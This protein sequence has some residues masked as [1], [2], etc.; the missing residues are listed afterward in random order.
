[1]AKPALDGIDLTALTRTL[2]PDAGPPYPLGEG[3][4]SRAFG[5]DAGTERY[6]LRIGT[7][8]RGFA[9]DA[10]AARAFPG[11]PVPEVV[12]IG[13]VGPYVY[14]LSRRLPG[15][16]VHAVPTDELGP[17]LPAVGETL[18]ALWATDV[19]GTTGYGL[20][21]GS[22]AG[23]APTW[24][25]Y[26]LDQGPVRDADRRG[27]PARLVDG[28]CRIVADRVDDCPEDR[29]LLHGDFG[30]DNAL[31]DGR[32]IT[33]VLNWELAA[34]GDPL[35]DVAEMFQWDGVDPCMTAQAAWFRRTLPAHDLDS[36]RLACYRARLCL[37]ELAWGDA[38]THEW[39]L[40]VA[41]RLLADA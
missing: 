14:C 33:G 15:R 23:A 17:V 18:A 10:Y 30:S 4:R 22:G 13:E 24:R 29:R 28:L 6:V 12:E 37:M 9:K 40:G 21:D 11:L 20:F 35:H 41:A 26:L 2:L 1:M 7:D 31:T 8:A 27:I 16:T 32:R 5:L 39:T 36:R 3:V 38:S 34:Y 19:A 25:A